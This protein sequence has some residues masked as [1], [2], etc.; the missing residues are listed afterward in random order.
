MDAS[1]C[2]VC[3]FG[4]STVFCALQLALV[5]GTA[6]ADL[7]P[8]FGAGLLTFFWPKALSFRWRS[9]VALCL[10]PGASSAGAITL[11][12]GIA[13]SGAGLQVLWALLAV[14]IPNDGID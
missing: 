5:L 3:A 9:C 12:A 1:F 7:R 2:F 13:D 6:M 8:R 11:E 14:L 10:L 4:F